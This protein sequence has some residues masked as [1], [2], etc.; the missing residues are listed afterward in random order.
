ME[1]KTTVFFYK[2]FT[3]LNTGIQFWG[4]TSFAI[5]FLFFLLSF[6]VAAQS[7]ISGKIIDSENGNP[8][9]DAN[10]MVSG[11]TGT[12]SDK[13][14]NFHLCNLPS[15]STVISV[16]FMG[17]QAYHYKTKLNT[18]DNNLPTFSIMRFLPRTN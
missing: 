4:R 17:F 14:G 15:D 6:Q 5:F 8:V 7:C 3:R 1:S 12:T 2:I 13:T 9:S 10:I 18:G 16:S 11:T